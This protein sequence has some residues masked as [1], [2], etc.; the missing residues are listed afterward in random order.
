MELTGEKYTAALAA[1]RSDHDKSTIHPESLPP[2]M[3]PLARKRERETG[4]SHADALAAIQLEL[5]AYEGDRKSLPLSAF[6]RAEDDPR[7]LNGIHI[8]KAVSKRY[9]YWPIEDEP[10]VLPDEDEVEHY[11]VPHPLLRRRVGSGGAFDLSPTIR[12]TVNADYFKGWRVQLRR[13]GVSSGKSTVIKTVDYPGI[14]LDDAY[15]AVACALHVSYLFL[16]DVE[17]GESRHWK[18]PEAGARALFP[19]RPVLGAQLLNEDGSTIDSYE[20]IEVG[21][22]QERLR[23]ERFRTAATWLE[24]GENGGLGEYSVPG[25]LDDFAGF[26]EECGT[27]RGKARFAEFRRW[28]LADEDED[29]D[30]VAF[31]DDD[32]H[33]DS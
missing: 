32:D 23:R 15:F 11:T 26:W 20:G 6:A 8:S 29:D 12:C 13:F 18:S 28:H 17:R 5:L 2:W 7:E 19:D 33:V 16:T 31:S 30:E 25:Q 22:A 4:V 24:L 10:R 27:S 9:V 3:E 1:I 21:Q 14:P